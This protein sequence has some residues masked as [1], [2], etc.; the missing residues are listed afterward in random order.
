[1]SNAARSF[2]PPKALSRQESRL[3]WTLL[4]LVAYTLMDAATAD[5]LLRFEDQFDRL[6]RFAAAWRYYRGEHDE[7]IKTP[8]DAL[9]INNAGTIVDIGVDYLFGTAANGQ[10]VEFRIAGSEDGEESPQQQALERIWHANRKNTLL[11]DVSLNGAVTGHPWLR[12]TP[13]A[14]PGGLPRIVNLDPATVSVA[15]DPADYTKLHAIRVEWTT[16]TS[17]GVEAWREDHLLDDNEQSWTITT[18]RT[19]VDESM[20]LHGRV[21]HAARWQQVGDALRWPHPWPQLISCQNLPAP[22]EYWGRS[23]I[24]TDVCTINDG[25]NSVASDARK[26]LRHFAHPKPVGYGFTA[27]DLDLDGGIGDMLIVPNKDARIDTLEMQSDLAAAYRMLEWLDAKQWE[28]SSIPKIAAGRV[29]QVGQMS[30]LALEILF[31][32]L[33]AKTN[34]KRDLYGDLLAQ[35]SARALVLAGQAARVEDV[36]IELDWPAVLPV[37][38]AEAAQTAATIVRDVGGS[39]STQLERLGLDPDVEAERRAQESTA[40]LGA[41][42]ANAG[43]LADLFGTGAAAQPDANTEA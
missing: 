30:S 39:A 9:I 4:T 1:M 29:D 12:I 41:S 6:Q 40:G 38:E 10:V 23:D 27:N 13:P 33:V 21:R 37:N 15:W 31:R 16:L 20:L 2:L 42:V 5:Y 24:E 25:L 19:V 17:E 3:G 26:T 28:R 35:V 32:P 14:I 22:N 18:S 7:P 34:T 43:L 36:E 11:R 8:Q